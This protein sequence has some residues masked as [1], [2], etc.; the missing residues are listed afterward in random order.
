MQSR[1]FSFT[2]PIPSGYRLKL[3]PQTGNINKENFKDAIVVLNKKDTQYQGIYTGGMSACM[4]I[5]VLERDA[6]NNINN[7]LMIHYGGGINKEG[8]ELLMDFLKDRTLPT[9]SFR[10][11]IITP[12]NAYT[13]RTCAYEE[14][15][16]AF[17][18]HFFA[19]QRVNLD[20][21]FTQKKYEALAFGQTQFT[22]VPVRTGSACVTFDGYIGAFYHNMRSQA[23][24]INNTDEVT[25]DPLLDREIEEF[26]NIQARFNN[27]K[28]IG[29]LISIIETVECSNRDRAQLYF[30]TR[31]LIYNTQFLESQSEKQKMLSLY[32]RKIDD[33]FPLF[34]GKEM[35]MTAVCC[36]IGVGFITALP[37]LFYQAYQRTNTRLL[38]KETATIDLPFSNNKV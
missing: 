26:K 5:T 9:G 24:R 14:S 20:T 21:F 2:P 36:L 6:K 7:L 4:A 37:F 19:M 16:A 29:K 35:L 15:I 10:E 27:N 3:A 17:K 12:G 31:E 32:R 8:L 23:S 18:E 38:L 28:I 13:S 11:V 1:T 33:H 25:S 34:L 30:D 22:F